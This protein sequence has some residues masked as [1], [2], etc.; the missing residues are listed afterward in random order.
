M[1]RKEKFKLSCRYGILTLNNTHSV[2]LSGSRF[3][4]LLTHSPDEVMLRW[5]RAVLVLGYWA[6]F[7]KCPPEGF[8][9]RFRVGS[10]YF[11][12]AVKWS[13][14][15]SSIYLVVMVLSY[16]PTFSG[17]FSEVFNVP[18][19]RWFAFD[20]QA[21]R[22]RGMKCSIDLVPIRYSDI[23]RVLT[24]LT[25]VF[26]MCVCFVWFSSLNCQ[27]RTQIEWNAVC[28]S[29]MARRCECFPECF[30]HL[31]LP[32]WFDLVCQTVNWS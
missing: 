1:E 25:K 24:Y 27:S 17:F 20:C 14:M 12:R 9:S 8:L 18:L 30:C 5:I 11:C 28:A 16:W 13:E 15:W 22:S 7:H 10:T 2:Y 31:P 26:T 21:V 32:R 4:D 29:F 23:E 6:T 19:L 3:H